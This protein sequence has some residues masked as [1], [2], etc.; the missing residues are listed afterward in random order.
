MKGSR[1]IIKHSFFGSNGLIK[2]YDIQ[3]Q[4]II[5]M[6]IQNLSPTIH[7]VRNPGSLDF[8]IVFGECGFPMDL[9]NHDLYTS[10]KDNNLKYCFD[11]LLRTL[12][13]PNVSGFTL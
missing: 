4:T 3:I 6:A 7:N 9:N 8:P 2:N 5:K 1:N 11:A 10:G 13:K 12:E